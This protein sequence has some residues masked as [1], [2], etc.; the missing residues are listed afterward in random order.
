MTQHHNYHPLSSRTPDV[1]VY[2]RRDTIRMH[3]GIPVSVFARET[4]RLV[5]LIAAVAV[6]IIGIAAVGGA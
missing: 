5:M 4:A 1:T 3:D 2:I 6:T